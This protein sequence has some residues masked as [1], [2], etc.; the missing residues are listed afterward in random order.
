MKIPYRKAAVLMIFALMLMACGQG[1][2]TTST[3][4]GG[5]A[6][7]A[8][9]AETGAAAEAGARAETAA[10]TETS[11][12]ADTA[13]TAETGATAAPAGATGEQVTITYGM[14][15]QT[16]QESMQKVAD[17]FEQANPNIQVEIQLVPW[18][19]YWD[20]LKTAA[21][22]GE[23]FDVFWMNGPF[24]P[25]YASRG[26]LLDLTPYMEGGDFDAA[27][28]PASILETYTFECK[29]YSGPFYFDTIGLF[30]NKDL[31]DAAGIP[32]PDASWDWNKLREVAGQ[33]TKA[34]D[35]YGL[36]VWWNSQEQT[37]NFIFSN[38]GEV[39]QDDKCRLTDPQTAEAVQYLVDLI[40][41]DKVSQE[42][43]A[44]GDD[45]TI[46]FQQ[47]KAAMITTGSWNVN[48]YKKS[49]TGFKWDVAPL[50][51]AP[52]GQSVSVISGLG[53]VVNA[54][55]ENPDAAWAWVQFIA[56]EQGQQIIA[57]AG[58]PPTYEGIAKAWQD[59][60]PEINTQVFLDAAKNAH[61]YPSGIEFEEW[62][63]ILNNAMAEVFANRIP[64]EQGLQQACSEIDAILQK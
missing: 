35:Q 13:A 46:F 26:L 7:T 59:A 47:G 19:Q 52:N 23:L 60:N 21:A 53:N 6:D 18:A 17:A 2:G 32:Y 45:P 57:E 48:A 11:A 44:M 37:Y 8:T 3:Q 38:G 31:F 27:K 39:V 42:P 40:Y 43:A 51:K 64:V 61:G 50:P 4:P 34:P 12:T 5:A 1:G 29:L 28:H 25:F 22:G 49:I 58:Q 33:L 63:P 62:N 16:Q 10:T 9:T 36:V 15:D 56:S 24:F 14:W 41:K 55:T 30:Y 54:K 20:N